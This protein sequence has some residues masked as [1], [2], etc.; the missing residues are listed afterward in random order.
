[1]LILSGK[2]ADVS[3]LADELVLETSAIAC[4]FKSC[5]PHHIR[6]KVMIPLVLQLSFFFYALKA[7]WHKALAVQVQ[8]ISFIVS[9]LNTQKSKLSDSSPPCSA[10]S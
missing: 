10:Q 3:E 9:K 8:K 4:R 6:T 7:L 5:H 1:M 2:Y